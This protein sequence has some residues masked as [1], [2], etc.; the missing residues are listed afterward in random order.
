MFGVIRL[1]GDAAG[2]RQAE[3]EG[4]DGLSDAVGRCG[5]VVEGAFGPGGTEGEL[6]GL[7]IALELIGFL[8]DAELKA[9]AEGMLAGRF[10]KRRGD[11]VI[12]HGAILIGRAVADVAGQVD[13]RKADLVGEHL[14]DVLRR[15]A[16]GREVEPNRRSWLI[17]TADEAVVA[18]AR[19]QHERRS[20]RGDVINGGRF[21]NEVELRSDKGIVE[22][23]VIQA[24]A[25]IRAIADEEAL[26]VAEVL[27]DARGE[28]PIIGLFSSGGILIVR[29]TERIA[30]SFFGA[31][32]IREDLGADGIEAA[33]R[34][35]VAWER[36][37]L[38]ASASNGDAGGGV[39]DGVLRSTGEQGGEV[40]LVHGGSGDGVGGVVV[41]GAGILD[42]FIAE[43]EE[44][45]VFPAVEFGDDDGS[46]E[47][48]A[49][50]VEEEVGARGT[51]FIEEEIIGPEA[52][53]L[54]RI[55]GAAVE[56]IGAAF[57]ADIGDAALSLAELG[58][59]GVGLHLEFLDDVGGGHVG[60]GDFVGVGGGGS[61]RPVDGDVV[62]VA[63][64]SAHGK[65]DDV[66]GFEGTVEADAAVEGDSGGEA[67]EKEGVAVGEREFRDTLAV[68]DGAEGGGFG[69]EQGDFAGDG[70]LLFGAAEFHGEIDVEAIGDADFDFW[71]DGLLE[72]RGGDFDVIET[73][74]EEGGAVN[75]VVLGLEGGGCAHCGVADR[76]RSSSEDGAGWIGDATGD[77]ATGVL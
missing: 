39:V 61:G 26:A 34:D 60:S 51:G 8:I 67:D 42:A 74:L 49:P 62:K 5:R 68:D 2:I 66:G 18:V 14:A 45:L 36:V 76:D 63:A 77:C 47:G 13:A 53:A 3:Q 52:G 58:V 65:I 21:R 24:V 30:A 38:E 15:E 17:G 54:E 9:A 12:I 46:T 69:I 27:V 28:V 19:V 73:G 41:A 31:G 6:A 71:A 7:L 33:D 10:G 57:D 43:E 20:E 44:G 55:I 22:V 4:G 37:L 70:D 35:L 64:R 75:A 56:T 48:T 11:R 32:V 16:Q 40:A 72:A 25:I 29:Q 23:V 1:A 59:E 50:A